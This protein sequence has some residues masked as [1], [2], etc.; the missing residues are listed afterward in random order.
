MN[1]QT[2]AVVL[3]H[4]SPAW[5][6]AASQAK[7][8]SWASLAYMTAEGAIAIIAAILAGSVALL[9]LGFDSVIEGAGSIIIVWRFSGSRTLSESAERRAQKAVAVSFFAL[10]P[11]VAYEAIAK[12]AHGEHPATSW[13]G[14]G[15]AVTS[16]IIM[17]FLGTAK[18]RLGARLDSDATT[19]SGVQ[20][21]LCAYLAAAVLAGLLANTLLGWWWLDPAIGMGIAAWAIW[22]GAEAWR[23]E[24]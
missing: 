10:A 13:L 22:E 20:N 8:L 12:L 17:P 6:R 11:Y 7:W 24:E 9:G 1:A 14:M 21:L 3:E 5:R 19:G 2:G 4:G 16:L 15:L 23:G 18:K